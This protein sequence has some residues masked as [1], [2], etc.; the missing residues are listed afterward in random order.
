MHQSF[1]IQTVVGDAA[2]D[3]VAMDSAN[4]RLA[5]AVRASP[6]LG[7]VS[8]QAWV[9]AKSNAG[10]GK[11]YR[12]FALLA[13]RVATAVSPHAACAR[14]C[15]HCCNIAVV[16]SEFEAVAIGREIGVE[17]NRSVAKDAAES[18]VSRYTGVPCTFLRDG[19]CSIYQHRPMQCRV[20]FNLA[21]DERMCDLRV[22]SSESSV[23]NV[24]LSAFWVASA[25][26]LQSHHHGDIRDFFGART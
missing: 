8:A 18:A 2:T 9:I 21:D 24:N 14:R 3:E 7:S 10:T 11:K 20:H 6:W 23:P 1:A 19:A 5:S 13:Q 12:R 22:P 25:Y 17:V 26:A 4:V 15:S 16:I